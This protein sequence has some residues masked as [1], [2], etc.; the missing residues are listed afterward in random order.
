MANASPAPEAARVAART[1][2]LVG[3]AL[4]LVVLVALVAAS[5]ARRAAPVFAPT[6]VGVPH[7]PDS[8]VV[9]LT[10]D[11]RHPQAWRYLDL[12]RGAV[13]AAGDSTGWDLAVQRFRVRSRAGDLG[14]WYRYGFITHLLEPIGETYQVLTD[15]GRQAVVEVISYYCP[16]LEAGCL[17]VRYQLGPIPVPPGP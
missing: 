16:G 5:L 12:D 7:A 3:L 15:A 6:A 2:L 14:R 9:Q 10:A 13:L 17:T 1:L 4:F 11:A 8:G